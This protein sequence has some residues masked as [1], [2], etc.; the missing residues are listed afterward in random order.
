MCASGCPG[1]H[2]S[3]HRFQCLVTDLVLIGPQALCVVRGPSSIRRTILTT[4]KRF[5][6]MY[7]FVYRL[8]KSYHPGPIL[9]IF[10]EYTISQKMYDWPFLKTFDC[11]ILIPNLMQ[12]HRL[13]KFKPFLIFVNFFNKNSFLL[14]VIN[15]FRICFYHSLESKKSV[16]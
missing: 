2:V 6:K 10:D 15:Y 1:H 3:N 12:W 14:S 16:W 8:A 13:Y 5:L 11:A 9:S 7:R 4:L